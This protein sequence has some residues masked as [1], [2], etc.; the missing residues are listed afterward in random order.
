MI[1]TTPATMFGAA[2]RVLQW[3]IVLAVSLVLG[4]GLFVVGLPAAL[5]LG[6]MI[7]AIAA[8][9]SGATIRVSNPL[10]L[11]AQAIVSM[12]I[13][14]AMTPEIVVAFLA[15]WPL[16]VA[17]VLATILASSALGWFMGHR[18]I[19]PG[20]TA[21]WGS[22]PGGAS[23]MVLMAEAAGADARLVALM[24]YMRVVMV[25]AGAAIVARF[26]LDIGDLHPPPIIWFPPL[27]PGPFAATIAVAVIG[28]IVG[29]WLP[30]SAGAM[31]VPMIAGATLQGLGLIQIALPEWLLSLAYALIGWRIGLGFTR[32]V[33]RHAA[34][35]MP[36]IALSILALMT[37][38]AL[39]AGLLVLL[40]GI[41]P[42]TA[43]LATSPGG[44]DSIAVIAASTPVDL[45]FVMALQAVRFFIIVL[46]G[47]SIAHFVARR[48]H[49]HP[50]AAP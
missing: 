50:P 6:P 27:E 8:G 41:D 39:L 5:L 9:L 7:A 18:R 19:V 21:V 24:Q 42:L 16:F 10:S 36:M 1:S 37:F 46:T 43:Y 38:S 12:L 33:V 20:T 17:V 47:P 25:A 15:D 45:S 32:A 30:I 4:G 35:V 29:R 34:R 31:I 11:A 44:M 26:A 23:A 48:M 13:A 22:S 2:P 28:T 40:L 14:S 3:I 49:P